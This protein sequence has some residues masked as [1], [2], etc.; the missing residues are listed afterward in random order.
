MGFAILLQAIAMF[1]RLRV[2][3]RTRLIIA[4]PVRS[5]TGWFFPTGSKCPSLICGIARRPTWTSD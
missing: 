3:L 4:S 5:T 1:E 2:I